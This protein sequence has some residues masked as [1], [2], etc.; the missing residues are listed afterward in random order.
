MIKE[1]AKFVFGFPIELVYDGINIS[2]LRYLSYSLLSSVNN[3]DTCKENSDDKMHVHQWHDNF[4]L[5]NF[6]VHHS[7]EVGFGLMAMS[8][9]SAATFCIPCLPRHFMWEAAI[10]PVTFVSKI[11]NFLT[12]YALGI[13]IAPKAIFP[14][15]YYEIGH[16]AFN[17]YWGI[18]EPIKHILLDNY[19]ADEKYHQY[20]VDGIKNELILPAKVVESVLENAVNTSALA[21]DYIYDHVEDW[22]LEKGE[23]I[24]LVEEL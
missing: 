20:I 18:I 3:K 23:D 10:L 15:N 16:S 2:V 11:G 21:I 8:A 13:D 6:I 22:L 19:C 12:E 17:L 9:I 5:N 4:S 7:K 14:I 24:K 1:Y